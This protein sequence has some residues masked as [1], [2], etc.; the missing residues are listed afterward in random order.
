M[1]ELWPH[2]QYKRRILSPDLCTLPEIRKPVCHLEET[3]KTSRNE[4][5]QSLTA[6]LV[7]RWS[8]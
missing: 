4:M 8:S 3:V 7:T 5:E 6:R 2:G 1:Q